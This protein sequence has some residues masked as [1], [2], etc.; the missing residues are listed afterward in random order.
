MEAYPSTMQVASRKGDLHTELTALHTP[1]V[2]RNLIRFCMV[3]DGRQRAL[4]APSCNG[5]RARGVLADRGAGLRHVEGRRHLVPEGSLRHYLVTQQAVPV[6]RPSRCYVCVMG[7]R[8]ALRR[9]WS[10]SRAGEAAGPSRVG[11]NRW[12][13]TAS[14]PSG[15]PPSHAKSQGTY[16]DGYDGRCGRRANVSRHS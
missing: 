16:L 12:V 4:A 7:V 5:R 1:W 15:S 8:P 11:L 2:C 10:S 3:F 13:L 6:L 9:G 14:A